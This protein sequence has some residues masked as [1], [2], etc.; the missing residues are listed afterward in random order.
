MVFQQ[1]LLEKAYFIFKL[2]NG[3]T[4][5]KRPSITDPD[6]DYTN[7]KHLPNQDSKTK[8]GVAWSS[9]IKSF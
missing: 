8:A 4:N 5:G 6:P 1:K 3:N 7:G 9:T 2:T